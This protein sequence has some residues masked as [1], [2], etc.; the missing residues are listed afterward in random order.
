[1]TN[2]RVNVTHRAPV[3]L[4]RHESHTAKMLADNPPNSPSELGGSRVLTKADIDTVMAQGMVEPCSEE[5]DPRMVYPNAELLLSLRANEEAMLNNDHTHLTHLYGD[6][7]RRT[8]SIL[9]GKAITA[10]SPQQYE[11][12]Q[13]AYDARGEAGAVQADTPPIGE[14]AP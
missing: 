6:R 7:T 2:Q 5:I 13:R 11:E 3:D 1:M 12:L 14:P 4:K 10:L 8:N 9:W